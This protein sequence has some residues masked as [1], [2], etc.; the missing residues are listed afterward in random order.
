MR[1]TK[2]E[3]TYMIKGAEWAL[4]WSLQ[5]S[6][7]ALHAAPPSASRTDLRCFDGLRVVTMA[8]VIIEHVPW[9]LTHT[10][11]SDTRVYEQ[12]RC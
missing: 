6:W 5:G 11:L 1:L 9:I 4:S 8:I 12:V 3:M 2:A 10:Y 7:R